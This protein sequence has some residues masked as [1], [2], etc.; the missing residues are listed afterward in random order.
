MLTPAIGTW[1][2]YE[3][4]DSGNREKLER[5]DNAVVIRP[6]PLALWAPADAKNWSRAQ[7]RYAQKGEEGGWEVKQ[8]LPKSWKLN[9]QSLSFNLYTTSF[10]HL[11]VF[12]EQAA[13]WQWILDTV[14]KDQKVLNLFGYTGGATL[15]AAAAGAAVVHVDA[16][17][18]SV[19]RARQNAE[20]SGLKDAPIR[21][22]E[23]DA[24]KFVAREI[25]RENVYDA[26][27]LDP[28]AFGRGPKGEIWKFE[29][30]TFELLKM[31][32]SILAPNGKLILNA[33]S[34]GYPAVSVEQMVKCVFPS[35]KT[36]CVELVLKE[37]TERGFHL[38]AGIAIRTQL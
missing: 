29:E 26:I 23:D 12:P 4:I 8:S 13:N 9:W 10:K 35:A 38:P 34:L 24:M 17:K 28:P 3:L 14:K 25:R 15:A 19:A 2:S 31:I 20:L 16:S 6:E 7:A 18:P 33:Y 21:W 30:H 22:I 27:F 1:S 11:G 36:E 32:R 5:F 37:S